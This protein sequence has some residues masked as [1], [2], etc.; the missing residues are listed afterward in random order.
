MLLLLLQI[1]GWPGERVS[2]PIELIDEANQSASGFVQL[3]P[4]DS[5]NQVKTSITIDK[6]L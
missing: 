2:I 6:L 1:S 3:T 4:V 5:N